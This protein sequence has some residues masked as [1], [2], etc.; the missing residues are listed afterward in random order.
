MSKIISVMNKNRI[1]FSNC[2]YSLTGLFL[3]Q[4]FSMPKTITILNPITYLTL[5]IWL[6]CTTILA[7]CF[8]SLLLNTYFKSKPSL[9]VETV[10][11]IANNP[12]LWVTGKRALLE[13][14]SF[15]PKIYEILHKRLVEYESR[16][17]ISNTHFIDI[18]AQV[19]NDII[20]RKAVQLMSTPEARTL[21]SLHPKI[22]LM[23]SKYKYNLKMHFTYV[24]K[25][26]PKSKQIFQM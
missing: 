16:Y 19:L 23:V 3:G 9:T 15:K 22:N 17:N 18:N 6:I 14:R 4:H 21:K 5:F 7:K 26:H 10:E 20:E 1:T 24:S 2:L 13:I 12:N 25:S 8:T 11:D